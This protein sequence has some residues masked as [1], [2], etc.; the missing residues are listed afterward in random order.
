MFIFVITN[1]F[2]L[3]VARYWIDLHYNLN[4]TLSGNLC[5]CNWKNV[6]PT[7]LIYFSLK[8]TFDSSTVNSPYPFSILFYYSFQ[9]NPFV[10]TLNACNYFYYMVYGVTFDIAMQLW[11]MFQPPRV[12]FEI[13][14]LYYQSYFGPCVSC[15]SLKPYRFECIRL[16]DFFSLC[17]LWRW[18]L[19]LG[20]WQLPRGERRKHATQ[21]VN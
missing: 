11:I 21:L 13:L 6:L 8:G 1:I 19:S 9:C 15:S 16:R 17:A 7:I 14:T 20:E 4:R 3:M 12:L 2:L 10:V 18:Q 5:Y